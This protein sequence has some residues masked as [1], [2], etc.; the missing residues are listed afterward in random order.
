M[1]AQ[2]KNSIYG[3]YTNDGMFTWSE[4]LQASNVTLSTREVL[5]EKEIMLAASFDSSNKGTFLGIKSITL[6]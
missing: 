1:L 2:F 6:M 5:K 4:G 3:N